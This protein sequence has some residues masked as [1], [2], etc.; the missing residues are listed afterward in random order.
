MLAGL[1]CFPLYPS[2]IPGTV[3]STAPRLLQA[4]ELALAHRVLGQGLCPGIPRGLPLRARAKCT[5]VLA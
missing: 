2:T 4:E 3:Q 5:D 1:L